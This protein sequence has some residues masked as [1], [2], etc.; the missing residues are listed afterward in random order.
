VP[1]DL[2]AD[3]DTHD[4]A[5]PVRVI[6]DQVPSRVPELVPLRHARMSASP[7]A[8]F[9]GAAAVM[10]GDLARG[11]TSGLT[12]QL[13]GDAH[14]SNFGIFASPERRLVFDLNDFDETFPGPWEWDVKRLAASLVI[15]GRENGYS[16]KQTRKTTV[17]ALTRYRDAMTQFAGLGNLAVWYASADV[18]E[19]R[20]RLADELDKQMSKRF[21]GTV[22]KARSRDHLRSLEKLT[23]VVDGRRRFVADPPLIV[24]LADVVTDRPADA[25]VEQVRGLV[26]EYAAR[27]EHGRRELVSSY[28]FVD[29]A[30]KVVGVGS[31]GTRCWVVLMQGRDE[32]DPLLLQVKEAQAS[33]LAR[34]LGQTEP[35][36]EGERVVAGQRIMQATTD[37]FLGSQHAVG[38]DGRSRDFYIRQLHDWKGS[39]Q[40]DVMPFKG[41][42]LYGQ[43]CAWTLARAHARSGDRIAIA[44]YL[45]DDDSFAQAVA[46][47]ADAYADLNERDFARFSAAVQEDDLLGQRGVAPEPVNPPRRRK[48][49]SPSTR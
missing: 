21:E 9:R 15:A 6:G 44:A 5:D 22:K 45:G 27:L 1:P 10:A 14:L 41:M 31:V 16:A 17:A 26:G 4:R 20:R 43:L 2:Q 29:M 48:S 24:P 30:R 12:V 7:F 28:D 40:V 11:P 3:L 37:I 49:A 13:C 32:N 25:A 42:Q 18:D 8:F 39:A 47:F 35:R 46:D 19:V 38:L 34:H 36:D 33:V 23:T